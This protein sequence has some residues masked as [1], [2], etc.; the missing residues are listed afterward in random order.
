VI[1][2]GESR[3]ARALGWV[4]L[5]GNGGV[6]EVMRHRISSSAVSV[7]LGTDWTILSAMGLTILGLD[8]FSK[9]RGNRSRETKRLKRAA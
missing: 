2:R 9:G 6:D 3:R 4:G 7:Y 1:G 8:E 5:G